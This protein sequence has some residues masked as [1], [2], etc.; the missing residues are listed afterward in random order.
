M[1]G[2]RQADRRRRG[3]RDRG[4]R[5]SSRG[6]E[7]PT[8]SPTL[9]WS[10]ALS[11]AGASRTSRRR[12]P[13]VAVDGIPRP[14]RGQR[15]RA[16]TDAGV[17]VGRRRLALALE[18]HRQ[19]DRPPPGLQREG[20][21]DHARPKARRLLQA[22]DGPTEARCTCRRCECPGRRGRRCAGR[23]SASAPAPRTGSTSRRFS[24]RS[25]AGGERRTRRRPDP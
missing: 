12:R 11:C 1:R 8:A 25:R 4:A 10:T 15:S 7:T 23:R 22:G 2:L 19:R 9:R 17:R 5:S 6:G 18:L 13:P 3:R 16:E 21:P 24:V 14:D 20:R